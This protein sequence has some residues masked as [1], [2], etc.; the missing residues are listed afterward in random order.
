VHLRAEIR[1]WAQI[2]LL[3]RYKNSLLLGVDEEAK[4][5]RGLGQKRES[6]QSITVY[7]GSQFRRIR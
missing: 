5:P 7:R 2:D 6:I 3:G 4:R 1:N